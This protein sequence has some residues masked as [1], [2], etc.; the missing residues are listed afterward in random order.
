M[1][2]DINGTRFVLYAKTLGVDYSQSAMIGRQGLHLS[3]SAFKSN[4]VELGFSFGEGTIDSIFTEDDGYAEEFLRCLGANE[5]HSF[6]SSNYEGATHVHNMN[7]DIPDDYKEQ[8]SMVIDGGSLEHVFNFPVAIKNCMQMIEIGGH[9][10]GI[11]PANNFLGHGFYQFSPE[12]YFSTF[13]MENGFELV[14]IIAFEDKRNTDWF[15]VR[16]PMSVRGRVTL[17]N[18]TPVYLLVIAKK[19][20]RRSI[21]ETLPEQSDYVTAWDQSAESSPNT[22]DKRALISIVKKYMP[23][24]LKSPLER[25]LRRRRSGFNPRYFRRMKPTDFARNTSSQRTLVNSRR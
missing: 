19:V 11:T 9:Y 6:D 2:L 18:S 3:P 8:Y 4:A 24:T 7:K 20:A 1:G 17:T 15:S 10:L 14:D 13:T 21:F 5:I 23:K 22:V 25:I 12:L 16:S